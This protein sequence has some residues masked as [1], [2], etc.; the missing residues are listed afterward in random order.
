MKRNSVVAICLFLGIFLIGVMQ[1]WGFR[2]LKEGESSPTFRLQDLSG[3]THSLSQSK[4]KVVVILY[5]RLGQERSLK[6]L[7]ELKIIF[8]NLS[9]QPIQILSIIKDTNKLSEI[10][11]LKKSLEIPFPILLDSEEEV[12]S[13][14]GVFVFPSTALIDKK[15]VYRFHYGGF[16]GNYQDEIYDQ[17]RVLLDLITEEQLKTEK[18][19][20]SPGLTE[21]QKRAINHIKLGERLKDRG[22]DGKAIQ[23]FKKA[24]ELDPDN[25]EGHIFLGFSLLDQKE[26]DQALKHFQKGSELDSRSTDVRIGLGRA[27]R[28]KGQ[29]NEA[30]EILKTALNLCPDSAVIHFELGVIYESLG[31]TNDALKH[32]KKSTECYLKKRSY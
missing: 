16:R 1:C 4:G 24:V 15:G 19:K 11:T 6:A 25:P 9:D 23:E 7:K 17:M 14:F 21:G 27:Y 20:K 28:M 29:T 30:L 10:K 13:E 31:K 18:E 22:M 8:E 2:H 32:Y 26:I 3:K 5:W 12:Y